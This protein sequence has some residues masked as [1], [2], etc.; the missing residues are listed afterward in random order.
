MGQDNGRPY[1]DGLHHLFP[2]YAQRQALIG[3]R[4]DA[5]GTLLPAFLLFL[6]Q[7]TR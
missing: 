3:V 1:V 6:L 4:V 2:R 7:D 5:V